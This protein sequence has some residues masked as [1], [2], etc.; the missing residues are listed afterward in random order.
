MTSSGG[1]WAR[2]HRLILVGL[3]LAPFAGLAAGAVEAVLQKRDELARAREITEALQ[4]LQASLETDLGRGAGELPQRPAKVVHSPALDSARVDALFDRLHEGAHTQP[5]SPLVGDETF[6][7]RVYLDVAGKLPTP[8][9][10]E[11]FCADSAPDKRARLIDVLLASPDYAKNWARYWRDVFQFHASNPNPIQVRLP[12]LED[13]LGAELAR[14]AP[15]DEVATA[16]ITAVGRNDTNGPTNFLM[17]HSA[18]PVELA[19]EVS[20]VFMGVQIQCA[21]CHDHPTDP[22]TRKQFHEFAAFFA[23]L[24]QPRPVT[25]PGQGQLLPWLAS[26]PFACASSRLVP[27]P[28]PKDP[29]TQIPVAARFFL[30]SAE[31]P[32]ANGL[33]T[34]QRRALAASFVTGQDNPWFAKAFVN[35]IWYA[36]IGTGFYNP[37]DDLGPTRDA[38]APEVLEALSSQWQQGGYDVQWLFRTILNTRTYQREIGSLGSPNQAFFASSCPVRLR[39]DQLLD[40]LAH[41]LDVPL[42]TPPGGPGMGPGWGPGRGQPARG[43]LPAAAVQ[44]ARH[45]WW[46]FWSRSFSPERGRAGNDSAGPLPDEQPRAQPC[47]QRVRQADRPW[48][49]SRR[50]RPRPRR[51]RGSLSPRACTQAQRRGG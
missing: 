28:D 18:Q 43:S 20:R 32:V 51:A 44:P 10:I 41:A 50:H 8:V 24:R 35:R 14:N 17:A 45:F 4:K 19:G 29:Q 36:L 1:R 5:P 31:P 13:W 11:R 34:D 40:A 42:D 12:V 27:L 33:T 26:L 37:V 47:D 22:W 16:L 23:G 2:W 30:A 3:A 21:Q 25:P 39:A 15:W 7:R 48:P 38:I 6:V 9:Q 46:A 49:D